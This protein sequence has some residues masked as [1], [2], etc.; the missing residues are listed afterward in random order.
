MQDRTCKLTGV[1]DRLLGVTPVK[2]DLSNIEGVEDVEV[3]TDTM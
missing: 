1:M 2:T 3:I